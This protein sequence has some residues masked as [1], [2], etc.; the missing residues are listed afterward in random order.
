MFESIEGLATAEAAP[1][2][3]ETWTE[4]SFR[5]TWLRWNPDA[6][7]CAHSLHRPDCT[8]PE[9]SFERLR[10]TTARSAEGR[11][12]LAVLE[13]AVDCF[14]KHLFSTRSRH[15]RLF[16][17]AEAWLFADSRG[18]TTDAAFTF[19]YICDALGLERDALRRALMGTRDRRIAER[20]GR[21]AA[22]EHREAA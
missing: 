8:V 6:D 1:V 9:L 2:A 20:A 10:R 21:R 7:D 16:R 17:E 4:P 15:R 14:Q 11:L 3:V 22:T 19:D 13:D 12:A 18:K 5:A